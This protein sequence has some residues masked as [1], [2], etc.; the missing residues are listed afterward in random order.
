MKISVHLL[1][2]GGE[3]ILAVFKQDDFTLDERMSDCVHGLN[4]V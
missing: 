3:R 2:W 1:R 4:Y